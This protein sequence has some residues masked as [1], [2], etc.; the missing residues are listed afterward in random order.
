[1]SSQSISQ[2]DQKEAEQFFAMIPAK[3]GKTVFS[4]PERESLIA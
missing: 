3:G 1:M 4:F 2:I